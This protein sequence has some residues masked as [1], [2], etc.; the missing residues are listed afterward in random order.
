MAT[1][2]TWG[3][4]TV[5]GTTWHITLPEQLSAADAAVH[6]AWEWLETFNATYSRFRSDSLIGQLNTHGQLTDPPPELLHLLQYGRDLFQASDGHL[7][8]LTGHVQAARGYNEQIDFHE[9]TTDLSTLPDPITDL[10]F[11]ES[12]VRLR[13]G[14]VDLGSFGKGYAIDRVV[15]LILEHVPTDLL[16]VNGGGDLYLHNP[17]RQSYPLYLSHPKDPTRFTHTIDHYHG[18]VANSNASV[19]RWQ[20]KNTQKTY[21]HLIDTTDPDRDPDTL[22]AATV[23][24]PHAIDADANA[25]L[26]TLLPTHNRSDTRLIPFPYLRIYAD[27]TSRQTVDFPGQMLR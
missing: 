19:R 12:Y 7:N 6:T 21:S 27:H 3:P 23:C 5:L 24:A 2:R 10:E 13:F 16:L 18:S 26:L 22:A 9:R 15:A 8:F 4:Y 1:T 14:A 25:T 17:K 11:H 20:T